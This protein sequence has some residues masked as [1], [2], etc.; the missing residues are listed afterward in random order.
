MSA[1]QLTLDEFDHAPEIN[2]SGKD[3]CKATAQRSGEQCRRD[4]LPGVPYCEHHVHLYDPEAD[5]VT[6]RA[7]TREISG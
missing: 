3:R 4:S 1:Q 2:P 5:E 7:E 6:R